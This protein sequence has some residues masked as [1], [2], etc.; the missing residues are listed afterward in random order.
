MPAALEWQSLGLGG[1]KEI[2]RGIA[3]CGRRSNGTHAKNRGRQIAKFRL[4]SAH[5]S[6]IVWASPSP[7]FHSCGQFEPRS[8]VRGKSVVASEGGQ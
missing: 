8:G 7:S 4:H 1:R 6:S 5:S 2:L 3:P